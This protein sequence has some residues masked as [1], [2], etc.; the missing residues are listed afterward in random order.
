MKKRGNKIL[1][2]V[3]ITLSFLMSCTLIN[4]TTQQTS[5][6][7]NTNSNSRTSGNGLT[8]K[9]AIVITP[10][11][12]L[13]EVKNLEINLENNNLWLFAELN[14]GTTYHFETNGEGDP[15]LKIYKE[16]Q[17]ESENKINGDPQ[18]FDN[19]SSSSP[20]DA[21]ISY[22][23]K[24]TGGYYILIQLYAGKTWTG[25]LIYNIQ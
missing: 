16:N 8:P 12:T 14:A 22:T 20:D 25:K 15:T 23:A 3:A 6:N 13:Q 7:A 1:V 5:N 24:T 9:T 19:D 17:V 10:S 4:T 21:L 11:A 18:A 2:F